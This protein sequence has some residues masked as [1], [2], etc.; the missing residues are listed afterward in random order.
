[1]NPDAIRE[2]Y[3]QL[4]SRYSRSRDD[5]MRVREVMRGDYGQGFRNL[6]PEGEDPVVANLIKSAA[7]TMAQ[8]V[9]AMPRLHGFSYNDSPTAKKR[10]ERHEKAL[11]RRL[12]GQGFPY[13]LKQGAFWLCAHG[14]LPVQLMPDHNKGQAR[15]RF[16]DPLT[17]F[18]GSMS[19]EDVVPPDVLFAKQMHI[20]QLRNMYPQAAGVVETHSEDVQQVTVADYHTQDAIHIAVL[21]PTTV[22]IESRPN[23]LNRP[24]VWIG[25]DFSPDGQD[26]QGQFDQVVPIL[27]AQAKL[28]AMLM[29]YTEQQTFAE[30]VVIGEIESNQGDWAYGPNAVNVIRPQPQ[31]GAQKLTNNSSPQV[32]QEIDRL[33]RSMRIAG[34]FP[35]ALSGEAAASTATGRGIEKLLEAPVNENV[36]HYQDILAHLFTE[37]F[38]AIPAFERYHGFEESGFHRDVQVV[39]KFTSGTDP[40]TTV[41]LLQLNAAEIIPKGKVR[42][43]I[44]EVDDPLEAE[45]QLAAE[46]LDTVLQTQFMSQAEQ[47][48]IPPEQI[49]AVQR[50]LK[51]GKS[52]AEAYEE[53]IEEQQ[54]QQGPGQPPPQP[55]AQEQGAQT[56]ESLLGMTAE[57]SPMAGIRGTQPV[58]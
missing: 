28:M 29:S 41:R 9:G 45:R 40:A 5:A 12:R 2:R 25:R 50:K 46:Q 36:S 10:A 17:A 57:G 32:F 53:F 43:Q 23:P 24:T 56:L 38:D 18:P 21:E 30:T 35:P 48:A 55:P 42:D 27:L 7:R 11:N 3:R 52:F 22:L 47:G 34:N 15:I 37:V 20:D 49:V 33:E 4:Q 51:E 6:V 26:F 1:M 54:D 31:A 14:F 44:P 19:A 8:Q 39:P 16:R 13:L 58:G